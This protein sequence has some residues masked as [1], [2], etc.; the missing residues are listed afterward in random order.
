M[1]LLLAAIVLTAAA[2]HRGAEYDEQYT[3]F[4]TSGTPRPIWPEA[5]FP[6]ADVIRV[7]AGHAGLA[8]IAEDLRRT[9]VHPPLY[10]WAVAV[11]RWIVGDRLFAV[12]LLSV[13]CSLGAL[14]TVGPIARRC[15]ISVPLAMLLTFGCYGFAYTGAIARGFALAQ[16]L[17]LVGI[18]GALSG[19][20]L[21][22]GALLGAAVATNYLAV[23]VGGAALVVFTVMPG[24]GPPSTTCDVGT[25]K[26]MDGG[27]SPGMTVKLGAGFLPPVLI[28]AWFFLAQRTSRTGQFP[29]FELLP[30]LVRMARYGAANLSGGLPLYVS[31]T[32][33][34]A[35]TGTL[36]F[37]LVALTALMIRRW[38]RIATPK[39]R[40]FLTAAALA[41]PLGLLA[42]GIVFNNTPIE[43]RYL[44]FATPFV[45][46]LVAGAHPGR[47]VLA[48]I[49]AVQTASIAGLALRPETMQPARATA[50]AAAALAKDGVV[51]VPR[52]ND[53]AGI[54]GAFGTEAPLALPLLIVGPD[55]TLARIRARTAPFRR[56][57]LALLTQDA[58]SQA[59]VPAMRAAFATPD[60]REAGIGLNVVAYERVSD[61]E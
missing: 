43:L 35:V 15:G 2:W 22:G 4:V 57:V 5:A 27:P 42:L 8:T 61:K 47:L 11:W 3:M 6:A 28:A 1:V 24:E 17:T 23:F 39:I 10:F 13:V 7:Q 38:Q 50:M 44:S 49:F 45:A 14:A 26:A 46:L 37:G 33:R 48:G 19:R 32:A 18:V 41:T 21:L 20:R 56:V 12:R 34:P 53:G 36:A 9:D 51:L 58:T 30:A 25:R 60:W 52:G 29:P 55:E 54:V 40:V 59:T 31:D 16:L